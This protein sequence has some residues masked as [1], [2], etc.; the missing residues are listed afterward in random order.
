VSPVHV[1]RIGLT[2]LKGTRHTDRASV[3]LAHGGPV[4]DRSFCLVDPVRT[5]V[6][7]TV[8]N[9]SLLRTTVTWEGGLLTARLPAGTAAAVPLG[10]G[11]L[12]EADYWGRRVRLEQVDGPWAAAFSRHLGYDV[13]LARELPGRVDRVVYGGSVSLVTT[14]SLRLLAETTGARV[15]D[16]SFRATFTVDT[17]GRLAHVEDGWAGRRLRLGDAEIEVCGG[18]PRCALVDVDPCRGER[19]TTALSA[20]ARYRRTH[21]GILFGVDAVVTRPGRVTVGDPCGLVGAGATTLAGPTAP[22]GPA[23][24]AGEPVRTGRG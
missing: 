18:L 13:V 1:S 12:L 2:A 6:V 7:R 8:E 14:S 11:R 19:S 9:P 17:G 3:D 10:T 5:R 4:G 22:A 23:G 15:Q 16:A 20:L 24:A 21:D